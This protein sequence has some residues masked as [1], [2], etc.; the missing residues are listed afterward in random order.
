MEY[1]PWFGIISESCSHN[2]EYLI[3]LHNRITR[4]SV[5]YTLYNLIILMKY[6][7]HFFLLFSN[8]VSEKL[9]LFSIRI[10][11]Y[12]TMSPAYF[13]RKIAWFLGNCQWKSSYSNADSMKLNNHPKLLIFPNNKLF[14]FY[15]VSCDHLAANSS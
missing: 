1:N 3:E 5:L 13:L 10:S 7:F 14:I 12:M 6:Y 8:H 4:P 11:M 15:F 2:I 9:S